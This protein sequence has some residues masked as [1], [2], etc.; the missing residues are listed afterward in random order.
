MIL[1]EFELFSGIYYKSYVSWMLIMVEYK[2]NLHAIYMFTTK[3][4]LKYRTLETIIQKTLWNLKK[5]K[6][7]KPLKFHRPM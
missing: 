5:S 3:S 1:C 7:L 6:N 4:M 2:E